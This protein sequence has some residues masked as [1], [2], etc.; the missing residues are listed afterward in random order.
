MNRSEIEQLTDEIIGEAVLYLLRENLPINVQ[1]LI[2]T[3]RAMKDEESDSSRREL[4]VH[5]IAQV[6]TN[7]VATRRKPL[8]D[9]ND[10]GRESRQSRDNVYQMFDESLQSGSNKKH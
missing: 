8:R 5:V 6:S 2:R 4:L 1:A 3:L 9:E 10:V 7:L